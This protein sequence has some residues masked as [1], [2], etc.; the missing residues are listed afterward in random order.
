MYR[1]TLPPPPL[2][3]HFTCSLHMEHKYWTW[4][5]HVELILITQCLCHRRV[6]CLQTL[7]D[8]SI[9]MGYTLHFWLCPWKPSW[10]QFWQ[11]YI[12]RSFHMNGS[13]LSSVVWLYILT[14]FYL[15]IQFC[16]EMCFLGIIWEGT[17]LSLLGKFGLLCQKN[18]W[19]YSSGMQKLKLHM[20]IVQYI[21]KM[22]FWHEI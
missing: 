12:L 5:I 2:Y 22:N 17:F 21:C 13:C 20:L 15:F 1:V 19:E 7:L 3:V 6:F 8:V 14:Y 18:K 4:N 16:S 9:A 10:I 11:G